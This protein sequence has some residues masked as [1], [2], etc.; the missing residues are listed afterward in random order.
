MKIYYGLNGWEY[1]YDRTTRCWWAAIFDADKNQVGD[2]INT[3]TKAEI[4]S[5]IS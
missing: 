3:Y 2:A 1:W 5:A 4:E